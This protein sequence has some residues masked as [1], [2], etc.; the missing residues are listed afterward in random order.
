MNSVLNRGFLLGI[1]VLAHAASTVLSQELVPGD[2]I[3][4]RASKPSQPRRQWSEGVVVRFTPDNVWYEAGGSVSSMPLEQAEIQRATGRSRSG[5]G[6]GMGVVAGGAVGALAAT[7]ALDPSRGYDNLD[8]VGSTLG[9]VLM[10]LVDCDLSEN[11]RGALY[12][13]LIGGTLG[14]FIG[15]G[16]GRWETVELDQLGLG[17][18]SLAVS[19]RIRR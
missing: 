5:I 16:Y 18:G 10:G 6:M 12:G 17:E 11:A 1:V 14:Y 4:V 19:L 9:C 7:F 13:A 2:S 3:R 15:R 8:G